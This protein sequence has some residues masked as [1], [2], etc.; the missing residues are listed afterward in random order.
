[1]SGPKATRENFVQERF[2]I[3]EIHLDLFKHHLTFFGDVIGIETRPENEIGNDVKSNRKMIVENFGVEAN[4]F[5][6]GEGVEHAAD[7]NS[8]SRAM[9]S[10]ERRSVPLKTM[11]SIK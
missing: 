6:G 3:V 10:A 5:L 11:C 4:L 1:M 7:G 9:A 2:G 8:I